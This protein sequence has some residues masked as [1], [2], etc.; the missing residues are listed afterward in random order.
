MSINNLILTIFTIY[1]VGS[2][3]NIL[4]N[5]YLYYFSG[6]NYFKKIKDIINKRNSSVDSIAFIVSLIVISAIYSWYG[7]YESIN[8]N[9]I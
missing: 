8:H 9:Y 1:L 5:L 7:I 6:K 2:L 4:I 3:F